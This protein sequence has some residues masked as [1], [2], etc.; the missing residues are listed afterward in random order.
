M[1]NSTMPYQELIAWDAHLMSG[2]RF[3]ATIQLRTPLR[4]L[5]RHGEVHRGSIPPSIT[6]EPWEGSWLPV[7][8]SWNELGIEAGGSPNLCGWMASDI[9]PIPKDGGSYILFLI[10]VRQIVED[11]APVDERVV[12]LKG[13]LKNE[14]WSVICRKLG[15]KKKIQD[16]FFPKFIE[17]IPGLS[18][19]AVEG[20]YVAKLI[21]PAR[22]EAVPDATLLSIKGIGP[23]K[24]L[25]IRGM[26]KRATEM[27]SELFD[28]FLSPLI[29]THRRK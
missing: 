16:F 14:L 22:I 17:A 23:S 5:I 10:A 28:P 11:D 13:E 29:E 20:L 3:S 15:G 25:V 19:Q 27:N 1:N 8:K 2:Y 7:I 18:R 9:G 24:L 4:I 26:C 6:L 12:R 21:T